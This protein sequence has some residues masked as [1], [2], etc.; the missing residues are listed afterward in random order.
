MKRFGLLYLFL[1]VLVT[2]FSAYIFSDSQNSIDIN[3]KEVL[4][5]NW[6]HSYEEDFDALEVY[7]QDDYEFPPSRGRRGFCIKRDGNFIE[8]VIAP[9]D[10]LLP[11]SGSWERIKN[12]RIRV[13]FSSDKAE[14]HHVSDYQ[15]LFRETSKDRIVIQKIQN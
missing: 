4:D 15:I 5:K 6:L 3:F 11:V 12:N 1:V 2:A 9:T 14:R 10:G 8:F 13:K 7:R